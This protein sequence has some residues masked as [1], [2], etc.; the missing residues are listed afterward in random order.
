MLSAGTLR[1]WCLAAAVLVAAVLSV[2]ASLRASVSDSSHPQ[3]DTTV[4]DSSVSTDTLAAAGVTETEPIYPMSPERYRK[5]VSYSRLNNIWRFISF[6]VSVGV[7]SLILFTG[8]SARLRNWAAVARKSFLRLWLYFALFSV[9]A[10]VLSFPFDIYRNFMVEHAYGFSNQTFWQWWADDLKG[11]AVTVV[12]GVVPV[13]LLYWVIRRFRRWW[14]VFAI[15][16]VPFLI[17]LMVI[18]PVFIAP[19][20]NKFEP[21]KDPHL[22]EEILDLARKAGIEDSDVFQVD[23]SRQSNKL[24]AYVTGLF[25]TKRIVLYDTLIENFTTGEILFV[26]GH[27][28]GHYVMHH[29][30]WGVLFAAVFIALGLWLVN[31][32]IHVVIARFHRR[33]GFDHLADIA[34]LPLIMLFL[35]VFG[36]LF[37]PVANGVSRYFEHR[38]D[39]YGMEISGVDGETAATAFDKL[40]VFNLADP[41]PNPIIEFWFYDHPALKKRMAFVRNYRPAR[42]DDSRD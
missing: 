41:D 28:I 15:G 29:V 19:L 38:A 27:E 3:P 24:N 39:I 37:N 1:K 31:R 11:L 40:S 20:F 2:T 5:L 32:L 35:T 13:A 17:L 25:G 4:H 7:L 8:F 12:I 26:M 18:A 42:S 23:A 14:A 22:R 36:F 6:F 33:F 10:Y 21:L 16:A 30:W 34:S 9:A